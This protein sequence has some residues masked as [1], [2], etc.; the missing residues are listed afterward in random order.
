M[1]MHREPDG[2]QMASVEVEFLVRYVGTLILVLF[3]GGTVV[4]P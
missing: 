2:V 3:S 4:P 1:R